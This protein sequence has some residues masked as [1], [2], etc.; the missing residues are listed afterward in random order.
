MVGSGGPARLPHRT[1]SLTLMALGC[2]TCSKLGMREM[3][4]AVRWKRGEE[5]EDKGRKA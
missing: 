1:V 2:E 4:L 3:D 5:E